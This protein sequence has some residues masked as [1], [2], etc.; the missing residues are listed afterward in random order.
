MDL[1]E[2]PIFS[3]E[4]RSTKDPEK[5]WTNSEEIKGDVS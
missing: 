3:R 5:S 4:G 2:I 1:W